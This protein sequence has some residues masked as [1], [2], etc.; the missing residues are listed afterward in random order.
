[1]SKEKI[2]EEIINIDS[3]CSYGTGC[4]ED[5]GIC[6]RQIKKLFNKLCTTY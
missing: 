2:L 1:M 5:H 6:E 3:I 4:L